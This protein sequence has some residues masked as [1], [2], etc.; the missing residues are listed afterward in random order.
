MSNFSNSKRTKTEIDTLQC[1]QTNSFGGIIEDQKQIANLWNYHFWKL[2]DYLVKSSIND[3]S[4]EIHFN[5]E[6]FNFQPISLFTCKKLLKELNIRKPL[7]PFNIPA[8]ALKD[9]SNIFAEP[10]CFLI[11]AFITEGAFSEHLK[12]AR[13][14]PILKKGNS[15]DPNNYRPILIICALSMI[16]EKVLKEQIHHFLEKHNLLSPSQFGFRE[17]FST[18]DAF[19]ATGHIRNDIDSNRFVSAAFLDLSRAFDSMCHEILIEKLKCMNSGDKAVS[20]IKTYLQNQIQKVILPSC[21]S[22]WMK[23]YQGVQQGTTMGPL[24]FNNYVNFM[25]SSVQRP[26]QFVQHK[27]INHSKKFF[28]IQLLIAIGVIFV[29]KECSQLL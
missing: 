26:T 3:K 18:T 29:S 19:C 8:W 27:Q 4:P 11:N 5:D 14:T 7:G 17:K 15:E 25:R 13:I 21:S 6:S 28:N 10:L 2:G 22:V 1:L 16:F 9:C 12:R 20:M 24:L 23:L